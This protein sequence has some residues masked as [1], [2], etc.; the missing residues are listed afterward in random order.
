ME[1]CINAGKRGLWEEKKVKK[2]HAKKE[3]KIPSLN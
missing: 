2:N 1:I 3:R